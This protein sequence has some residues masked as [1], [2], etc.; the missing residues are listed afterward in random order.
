MICGNKD[1]KHPHELYSLRRKIVSWYNNHAAGDL[2]LYGSN[3]EKFPA[4]GVKFYSILNRLGLYKIFK[5]P[6]LIWKGTLANKNEILQRCE[7]NFCPENIARPWATSEKIFDAMTCGAIPV[8]CGDSMISKVVP[9]D[10]F[11]DLNSFDSLDNLNF[12][13]KN[14]DSVSKCK[15]RENIKAFLESSLAREV[16]AENWAK[17]IIRILAYKNLL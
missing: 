15:I 4:G 16:S 6:P 2:L 13:L 10:I 11:V 8:Y 7:F 14:L 17:N 1:S 9:A 12:F 5:R 3:W